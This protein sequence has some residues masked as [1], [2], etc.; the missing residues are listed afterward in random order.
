[1]NSEELAED[2]AFRL[3]DVEGR[4]PE[5]P[6]DDFRKLVARFECLAEGFV[7]ECKGFTPAANGVGCFWHSNTLCTRLS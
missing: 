6:K 2:L 7:E 1:M 3:E 5:I 4:K